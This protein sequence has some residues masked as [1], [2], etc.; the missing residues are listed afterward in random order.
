[1]TQ[2]HAHAQPDKG[3]SGHAAPQS[4]R[5]APPPA[6]PL[7]LAA[8]SM[9]FLQRTIGN[10]A[11][12]RLMS[13]QRGPWLGPPGGVEPAPIVSTD[14]LGVMESKLD[15]VRQEFFVHK[16]RETPPAHYRGFEPI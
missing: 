9:F 3:P 8:G 6:R 1:M 11:V 16:N 15:E 12:Q 2:L 14:R 10:Q 4:R 13:V 7:P 5:E